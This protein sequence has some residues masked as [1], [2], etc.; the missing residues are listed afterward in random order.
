MDVS[1]PAAK[2]MTAPVM[3][4]ASARRFAEGT[5]R[6]AGS[7]FSGITLDIQREPIAGLRK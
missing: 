5:I 2:G 3:I 6:S 4:D 1:F 7:E